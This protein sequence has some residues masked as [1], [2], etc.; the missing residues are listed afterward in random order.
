MNNIEAIH[1]LGQSLWLDFISRELHTSGELES[2][3]KKDEVRG[4]TSN[5]TIF[6]Q[7]IAKTA[8]VFGDMTSPSPQS[9]WKCSTAWLTCVSRVS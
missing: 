4:V 6:E 3:I 7:A 1:D 5:P 8:P 2:L 9:A